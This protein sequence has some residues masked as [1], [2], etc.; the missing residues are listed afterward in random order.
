MFYII[1]Q[2]KNLIN[3]KIY[4]G[5]HIAKKKKE[6][7]YLGSG[8]ILKKAIQKYGKENFEKL[9]LFECASKD[10]MY[11]KERELITEEFVKRIDTYNLKIGG[12]GGGHTKPHSE[13]TKA[14]MRKKWI[15]RDTSKFGKKHIGRHHS[16]EHSKRISIALKKFRSEHPMIVSQETRRKIS[17]AHKGKK[18]KERTDE[19]KKNLS[20]AMTGK[21]HSDETKNKMRKK[22]CQ[23]KQDKK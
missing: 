16:E 5:A 10:E 18:K 9:I 13:E 4:I 3:G 14:L 2:I 8:K 6:D 17:I 15:G 12:E 21:K 1:Y 7:G 23:K 11:A 22:S 20:I 19:H